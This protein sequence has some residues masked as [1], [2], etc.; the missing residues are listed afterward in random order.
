MNPD[1]LKNML[2]INFPLNMSGDI[3]FDKDDISRLF[4]VVYDQKSKVDIPHTNHFPDELF[5]V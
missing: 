3:H 4:D 1:M 5:E 2:D